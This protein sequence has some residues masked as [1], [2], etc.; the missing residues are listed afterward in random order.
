MTDRVLI[1]RHGAVAHVQLNRADKRNALDVAMFEGIVAAGEQLR[2]DR[3]VR[4]VVL[5]GVGQAFS[6]GLDFSAFS[7][8]AS[9]GGSSLLAR[10]AAVSPANLAQRVGWIWQELEVPVIAALHGVAFGGGFQIAAGADIRVAHPQTQ[11]SIME[12]KWGLV[13]D[14]SIT[15]TTLRSVPL[16]VIKDLMFTGRV[17]G[18]EE[19]LGLRLVTRLADDPVATALE[20]AGTIATKNPHA[21]RAGKRMLNQALDLD[22]PA[23]FRLE[24]DEQ[25]ALLG[26]ANQME[27]VM[28]NM[29]KRDPVFSD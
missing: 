10:D 16:D 12:I 20:L 27:A 21:I 29:Q 15:A 1:E 19:A 5:S 22:I 26:S 9:G 25:L 4:A 18:G 17:V 3:S 23:R 7:A 6:A 14:M 28:A 8:F 2:T 13:P 11:L 24:T